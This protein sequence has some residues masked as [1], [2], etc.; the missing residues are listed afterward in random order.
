MII[1][2]TIVQHESYR[3]IGLGEYRGTAFQFEWVGLVAAPGRRGARVGSLVS[4]SSQTTDSEMK[5]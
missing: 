5:D 3:F 1:I 2:S 4:F